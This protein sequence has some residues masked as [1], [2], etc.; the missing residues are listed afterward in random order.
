MQYAA[1]AARDYFNRWGS[2]CNMYAG[3]S[4]A[5]LEIFKSIEL[6][7]PLPWEK[8]WGLAP[9]ALNDEPPLIRSICE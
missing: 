2:N 6:I 7:I 3:L 9:L 1:V 8:W 5:K 4:F